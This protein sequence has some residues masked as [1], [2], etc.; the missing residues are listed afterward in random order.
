MNYFVIKLSCLSKELFNL[1]FGQ[2]INTKELH[3][4]QFAFELIIDACDIFELI[5]LFVVIVLFGEVNSYKEEVSF[6]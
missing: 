1:L 3:I 4:E 5:W 2:T 6:G